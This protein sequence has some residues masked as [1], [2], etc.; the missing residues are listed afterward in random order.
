MTI[1]DGVFAAFIVLAL[2]VV[3]WLSLRTAVVE[4]MPPAD[5][6]AAAIA[7]RAADVVLDRAL[8]EFVTR[9]GAISPQTAT[10][11]RDAAART[12][13]DARPYM[14][15]GADAIVRNRPD[16]VAVLEAGRRLDGR[17]R[18]IRL[19][20]LDRYIRAKRYADAAGEFAVLNRLVTGAQSPILAELARMTADPATR[21]AI[22]ETLRRDPL[23]EAQLLTTLARKSPDPQLLF[24]LASPAAF[25]LATRP[26]GWGTALVAGMVAQGRY[27]EARQVWAKLFGVG[28]AALSQPLYDAQLAGAPG[29]PPF[30]WSLAAGTIGAAERRAGQLAVEYYGRDN[31]AL[32]S[33]LLQLAPGAYRFGYS[34]AGS[35]GTGLAWTL[36]CADQPTAAPLANAAVPAG[37]TAV[38]RFQLSFTVPAAGCRAQWLRLVGNAAEFPTPVN[39]TI[40]GLALQPARSGS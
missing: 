28:A 9:R 37:G 25:T 12:P 27:A 6:R 39:V 26:D 1:A 40:S 24:G 30:N 31:G 34:V 3:G 13:L 36:T 14:F 8:I 23:L 35:P 20:L 4:I 29:A 16:A 17:N 33:Q 19:L 10:Q 32:A 7:P 2:A 18:W 11:V 15:A 22:K 38:K 21:P 5:P